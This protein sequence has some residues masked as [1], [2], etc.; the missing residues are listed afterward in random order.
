MIDTITVSTTNTQDNNLPTVSITFPLT[1]TVVSGEV[2][3]QGEADDSDGLIQKVEIKIDN[4]AWSSVNGT[5]TWSTLWNTHLIPNDNYRIYVRSYDGEK[6]SHN[7]EITVTV[8][9][10]HLPQVTITSP[11][12][13]DVVSGNLTIQGTASDMDGN[14]TLKKVQVR[15][16]TGEWHNT[17][18]TQTWQYIWAISPDMNEG[19]YIIQARA[20]DGYNYSVPHHITLTI[21]FDS[22]HNDTPGFEF[23][24]VLL[25]FMGH[26]IYITKK[27]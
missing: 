11:P 17:N 22:N 13:G 2:K 20:W 12:A 1:G 9:N 10:N 7:Q 5:T 4:S 16:N 27:K 15:I 25:A 3:I 24:I 19:P 8:F 6:Y 14:L 26:I 18:G 23:L 21:D